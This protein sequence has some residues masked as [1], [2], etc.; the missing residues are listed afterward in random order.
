MTDKENSENEKDKMKGKVD[1]GRERRER[2]EWVNT[3]MKLEYIETE[4][5]T[6]RKI[7][8]M[9]TDRKIKNF[10]ENYNRQKEW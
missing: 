6:V 7:L 8:K 5:E 1:N 4:K 10:N 3:I 2:K 9:I